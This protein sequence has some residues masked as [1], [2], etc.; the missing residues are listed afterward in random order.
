MA[1]GVGKLFLTRCMPREAAELAEDAVIA[2]RALPHSMLQAI[3]W[4]SNNH[5]VNVKPS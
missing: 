1:Y 3:Q 4:P 5:P 2:L